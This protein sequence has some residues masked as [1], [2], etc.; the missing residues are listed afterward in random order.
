VFFFFLKPLGLLSKKKEKTRPRKET[1][2]TK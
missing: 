1:L 2:I